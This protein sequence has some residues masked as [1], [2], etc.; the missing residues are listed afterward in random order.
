[1]QQYLRGL[2]HVPEQEAMWK[3]VREK[4]LRVAKP[5]HVKSGPGLSEF[6]AGRG[7]FATRQRQQKN[8]GGGGLPQ[9]TGAR[10]RAGSNVEGRE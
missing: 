1:M 8:N 6:L 3:D 2:E 9:R 7:E 4:H 5:F 10:P